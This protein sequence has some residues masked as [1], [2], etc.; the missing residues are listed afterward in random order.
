MENKKYIVKKYK[1][2]DLR[3]YHSGTSSRKQ[4]GFYVDFQVAGQYCPWELRSI[5]IGI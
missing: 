2:V 4:S 5:A 1:L 3:Q